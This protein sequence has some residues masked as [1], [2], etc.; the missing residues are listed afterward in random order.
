MNTRV[1]FIGIL[2]FVLIACG[3]TAKLTPLPDSVTAKPDARYFLRPVK[4]S[5]TRMGQEGVSYYHATMEKLLKQNKL[6]TSSLD[7]A[8]YILILTITKFQKRDAGSKFMFGAMAGSDGIETL[9]QVRDTKTD[10]LLGNGTI[11][12]SDSSIM[13]SMNSMV[14]DSAERV[15][16]YLR[17]KS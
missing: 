17:G 2:S 14:E 4:S 5:D 1:V 6:Y 11:S 16:E 12:Q 15:I 8:D 7:N 3:A 9:V 10:R 13:A